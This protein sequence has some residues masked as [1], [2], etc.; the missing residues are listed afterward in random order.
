MWDLN[1]PTFSDRF[2]PDKIALHDAVQQAASAGCTAE[3]WQR[4]CLFDDNHNDYQELT[5]ILNWDN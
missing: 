2:E 3:M 5:N 1:K 4:P